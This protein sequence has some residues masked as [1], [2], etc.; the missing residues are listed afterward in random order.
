MSP[1]LGPQLDELGSLTQDAEA[2]PNYR[3]DL[4][5]A[6]EFNGWHGYLDKD[7]RTLLGRPVRGR[8][9]ARYCGAGNL[10]SCRAALWEAVRATADEL[11]VEQGADPTAWRSDANRERIKFIPGLLPL[12]LRYANRPSGIQQV[13]TFGSHEGPR[14]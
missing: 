10:A 6:Q 5:P 12:T 8:F 13:I 1:V 14:R 4:P 7:L 9:N 2:P 3:F 11:T